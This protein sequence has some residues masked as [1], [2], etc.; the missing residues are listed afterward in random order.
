MNTF[1]RGED[2]VYVGR[3]EMDGATADRFAMLP[4]NYDEAMEM[5]LCPDKAWC[6]YVQK[7]RAAVA[8]LKLRY[9]VTPRASN[10][11]AKAL[12]AGLERETTE[13]CFIWRGMPQNERGKV[14]AALE[15]RVL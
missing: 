1:G 9:L 2:R 3:N 4:W 11:G 15:W 7:V 6:A 14:R 5:A 10:G 8:T 13:E 12:A